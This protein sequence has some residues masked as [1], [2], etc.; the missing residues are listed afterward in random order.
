[1]TVAAAG[2][3]AGRADEALGDARLRGALDRAT[4]QLGSRRTSAFL[5]L[6]HADLVRDAA[7]DAKMRTLR[8]LAEH[9][10]RFEAKLVSNGA[11]VHWAETPEAAD[12]AS[13]ASAPRPAAKR[14]PR[15][16]RATKPEAPAAAT[17]GE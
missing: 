2:G 11:Q 4:D 16:T 15:A 6:D 13:P 7:R 10:E 9:L 1:M 14:A 8:T 12:H 5:T 17:T 3:F